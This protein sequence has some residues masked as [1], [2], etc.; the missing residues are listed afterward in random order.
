MMILH[1]VRI[2]L[3]DEDRPIDDRGYYIGSPYRWAVVPDGCDPTKCL[4][5]TTKEEA[6][7]MRDAP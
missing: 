7:A 2:R 3:A 4:R 5:F 1:V 6:E